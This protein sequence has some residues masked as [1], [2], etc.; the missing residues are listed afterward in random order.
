MSADKCPKCGYAIALRWDREGSD[1]GIFK[2]GSTIRAGVFTSSKHCQ[3]RVARQKAEAELAEAHKH[4]NDYRAICLKQHSATVAAKDAEKELAKTKRELMYMTSEA[5]RDHDSWKRAADDL[6]KERA[7]HA[8]TKQ[9]L[10]TLR[11]ELA[12][13]VRCLDA[14]CVVQTNATDRRQWV[15]YSGW[16][17]PGDSL[18][19]VALPP[20]NTE[21]KEGK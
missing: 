4:L 20:K 3:E 18:C 9:H 12:E 13:A 5:D 21:A 19:E 6:A 15:T 2:C 11:A 8:E 17:S 16:L 14:A 1:C 10:E 7:A